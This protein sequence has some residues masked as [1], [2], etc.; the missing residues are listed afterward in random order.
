[1]FRTIQNIQKLFLHTDRYVELKIYKYTNMVIIY[2]MN[3]AI[4]T[5]IVVYKIDH[6][7]YLLQTMDIWIC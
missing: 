3:I 5:S 7:V 4:I 1:M 6:F 2:I